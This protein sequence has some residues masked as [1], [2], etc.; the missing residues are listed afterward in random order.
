[1]PEFNDSLFN[2]SLFDGYA[3]AAL[4][5]ALASGAGRRIRTSPLQLYGVALITADINKLV[6]PP[7]VPGLRV[8]RWSK[9]AGVLR[10]HTGHWATDII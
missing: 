10:I 5:V 2:D 7:L 9:P 6:F 4:G 1:M 3:A 8:R